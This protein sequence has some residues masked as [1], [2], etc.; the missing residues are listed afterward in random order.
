MSKNDTRLEWLS[1]RFD[2]WSRGGV[3]VNNFFLPFLF[4]SAFLSFS[5]LFPSVF[6]FPSSFLRFPPFSWKWYGKEEREEKRIEDDLDVHKKEHLPSWSSQMDIIFQGRIS[7]FP[8]TPFFFLSLLSSFFHSFLLSF[9]LSFLSFLSFFLLE[10]REDTHSHS[11]SEWET[12][13]SQVY[14]RMI[15]PEWMLR[16]SFYPDAEAS[17]FPK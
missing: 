5:S 9:F 14:F 4:P 16:S 11:L 15:S 12:L 10:W 3:A 8:F 13:I 1:H 2:S 17:R 7:F 6:F